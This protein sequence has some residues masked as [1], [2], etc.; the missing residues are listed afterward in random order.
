MYVRAVEELIGT[1]PS[2]VEPPTD[3]SRQLRKLV[4]KH[5]L[6]PGSIATGP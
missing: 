2:S 1:S 3:R 5:L 4:E 6:L